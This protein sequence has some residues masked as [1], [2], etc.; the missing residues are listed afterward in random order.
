MGKVEEGAAIVSVPGKAL[1]G[2]DLSV[3]VA[4]GLD[5]VGEDFFVLAFM[6]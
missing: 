3:S 5:G 2:K 6:K 1:A 4:G